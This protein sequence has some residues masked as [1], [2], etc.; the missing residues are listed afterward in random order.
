MKTK[1]PLRFTPRVFSALVI[2]LISAVVVSCSDSDSAG[3][4]DYDS[5]Q[6]SLIE[7]SN[8]D[9]LNAMRY[10]L[11]GNGVPDA[12]YDSSEE[13]IYEAAFPDAMSDMG[14]P[15]TGCSGYEL[16]AD[17]DFNNTNSYRGGAVNTDWTTE[18]GWSPIGDHSRP[19]LA[20]FQGNGAADGLATPSLTY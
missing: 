3:D 20:D 15:T 5:D 4:I 19:F 10:D 2:V 1:L 11:D 16:V 8:L 13:D 18:S 17:L 7:I 12:V 6:D 9:Q 14:C